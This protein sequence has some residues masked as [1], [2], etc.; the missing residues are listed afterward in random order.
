MVVVHWLPKGD[1]SSALLKS[2]FHHRSLF[3]HQPTTTRS[4]SM[5]LCSLLTSLWR[6][7]LANSSRWGELRGGSTS[8]LR[9]CSRVSRTK[10][11]VPGVT[12]PNFRPMATIFFA[13]TSS[14]L[15][16]L[17]LSYS[18]PW[19]SWSW[20]E[21]SFSSLRTSSAAHALGMT[22]PGPHDLLETRIFRT[23][24]ELTLPLVPWI[25]YLSS[26]TVSS[27]PGFKIPVT[28]SRSP[29]R[30]LLGSEGCTSRTCRSS[31]TAPRKHTSL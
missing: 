5:I 20:S 22:V 4:F 12:S 25:P 17:T 29:L 19:W 8:C 2:L 26:T 10:R 6:L 28:T 15:A 21:L 13:F 3:C 14:F 16:F 7:L 1:V 27:T 24:T 31:E 30:N 9:N 11:D 18:S 23:T